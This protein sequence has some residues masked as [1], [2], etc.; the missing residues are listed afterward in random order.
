M[1]G[2]SYQG[3]QKS[4][5]NKSRTSQRWKFYWNFEDMKTV[6]EQYKH[7]DDDNRSFD[8]A[9]WQSQNDKAIFE[10]AWEMLQDYF[11]IRGENADKPRLQRTVESFR[12][13]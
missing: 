3:K 5:K 1:S 10:A 9:F 8:I 2:I 11:L 13:S 6:R 7:I 12:K 4:R